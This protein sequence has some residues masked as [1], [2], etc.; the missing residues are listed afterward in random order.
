[1]VNEGEH[2]WQ[3]HT[4]WMIFG[5]WLYLAAVVVY[6]ILGFDACKGTPGVTDWCPPDN[7]GVIQTI[8]EVTARDNLTAELFS[9]GAGV[10]LVVIY[11]TICQIKARHPR[12]QFLWP[13]VDASY[14]LGAL[15]F[16]GLTVWNLRV[17]ETVHS[18]FTAQTIMAVSMQVAVLSLCSVD[19]TPWYRTSLGVAQAVF[20]LAGLEYVVMICIRAWLMDYPTEDTLDYFD[21]KYYTH[22]IGQYTFFSMYFMIL[23]L[24]WSLPEQAASA[25]SAASAGSD[26]ASLLLGGRIMRSRYRW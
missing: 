14:A 4:W 21:F 8:S 15:G 7:K 9:G 11:H 6:S 16:V 24:V 18:C 22:A 3:G 19:K 2:A 20:Y 17:S 23:W 1:M 12:H 26:D 25:A 13:I 5:I 10:A